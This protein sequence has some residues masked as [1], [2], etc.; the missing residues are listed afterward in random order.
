VARCDVSG[1]D[2]LLGDLGVEVLLGLPHLLPA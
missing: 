2:L 1:W